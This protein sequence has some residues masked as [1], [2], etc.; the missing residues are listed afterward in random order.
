MMT[1]SMMKLV[2]GLLLLYICYKG[3]SRQPS[4]L[5]RDIFV[6]LTLCVFGDMTINFSFIGG[7]LMFGAA[8]A[9]LA[10]RFAN[11][12][13]PDR[14]QWI[15]WA[16]SI[17]LCVFIISTV[18]S[19][20]ANMLYRMAA[21]SV[22]LTAAVVTSLTM[23]KKIRY[24]AILL[25]IS[26]VLLFVHEVSRKTLLIHVLS[27]GIYYLAFGCFAF[28]TKYKE[29]LVIKKTDKADTSS[30]DQPSVENAETA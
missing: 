25:A 29:Q 30:G 19:V 12:D 11:Y 14:W 1:R 5:S 24:G 27:L 23:P 9:V 6:A 28:A 21:Y 10:Y 13:K 22:I 16:L 18:K 4:L 7:M 20:T 15:V 17:V 3:Y 2:I 8:E 26:N